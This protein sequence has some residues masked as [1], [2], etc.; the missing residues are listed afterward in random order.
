MREYALLVK[1]VEALPVAGIQ[2]LEK[3][4]KASDDNV[5]NGALRFQ[6]SFSLLFRFNFRFTRRL[7]WEDAEDRGR[8][9]LQ[10][11]PFVWTHLSAIE[12]VEWYHIVEHQ[13]SF[14]AFQE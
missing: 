8:L 1:V 9:L 14:K 6:I 2:G 11:R 7:R 12:N 5:S 10:A 3:A 13:D 4:I